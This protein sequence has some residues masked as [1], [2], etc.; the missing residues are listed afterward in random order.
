MGSILLMLIVMGLLFM[1]SVFKF[2][3][4][5][6]HLIH[7]RLTVTGESIADSLESAVDLGLSLSELGTAEALITRA[8]RSDPEIK[9][10]DIFGPLGRVYFSTN[11][12]HIGTS[13][14]E[15]VLRL[16]TRAQERTWLVE[17]TTSFLSGVTLTDSIG[18]TIGGVLFTYSKSGFNAK[19]ADLTNSLLRNM[20][21]IFTL[22]TLLT[23]IG[24]RFGFR[25]LDR[26]M[27]RIELAMAVFPD[28]AGKESSENLPT[29]NDGELPDPDI[30][31]QKLTAAAHQMEQ[32]RRTIGG[33]QPP[34]KTIR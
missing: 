22:F 32:A 20:A 9:S 29:D 27:Q 16:Q 12:D 8:S 10:V 6:T 2:E 31:E 11:P 4:S 1:M 33:T 14:A 23:Y 19:V 5:L 15:S 30:V 34:G 7:S 18:R 21:L 3:S 28:L 24:I 25:D 13:T 26:Y 17:E